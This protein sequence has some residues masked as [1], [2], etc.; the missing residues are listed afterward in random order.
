MNIEKDLLIE[1]VNFVNECCAVMDDGYV[2]DWLHKPNPDLNMEMPIETFRTG[3]GREKLYRL[4]YF[5]EIG[6]ADL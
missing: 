3:V 6:E 1:F 4:L 2:A 5:I